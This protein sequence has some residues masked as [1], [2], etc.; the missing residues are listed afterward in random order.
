MRKGGR[1]EGRKGMDLLVAC[2]GTT[3]LGPGSDCDC[4]LLALTHILDVNDL[5]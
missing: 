4:I 5:T 1:A 2:S 3:P